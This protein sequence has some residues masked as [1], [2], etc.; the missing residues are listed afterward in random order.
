MMFEH[1]AMFGLD[2]SNRLTGNGRLIERNL[3]LRMRPLIRTQALSIMGLLSL[4]EWFR[5]V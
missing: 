2:Y 4:P 1:T 3:F 5:N